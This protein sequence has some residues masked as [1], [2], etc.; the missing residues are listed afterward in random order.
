[1]LSLPIWNFVLPVYAYWHFDDFSWGQ[2][3]LVAGEKKDLGHGDKVGD[4]IEVNAV[5]LR[6]WEDWERSRLRRLKRER[7]RKLEFEKAFGTRNFHNQNT[8][9][10][11]TSTE[12]DSSRMDMSDTGSM[13]SSEDDRWGLQIGQYA[14]ESSS[15]LPPVGLYHIDETASDGD[16]VDHDR[17]EAMLDQGWDDDDS[18]VNLTP[19]GSTDGHPRYQY[20]GQGYP[21][22]AATPPPGSSGQY[23]QYSQP[24][25]K[26][27]QLTDANPSAGSTSSLTALTQDMN[28]NN[29]N[30]L[31]PV[32]PRRASPGRNAYDY[33]PSHVLDSPSK[34]SGYEQRPAQ[35]GKSQHVKRRSGG[36]S[37]SAAFDKQL[38]RPY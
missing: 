15:Y 31:S 22:N 38:P 32:S 34:A 9:S 36:G 10:T 21:G 25:V 12:G 33:P 6:R 7:K 26:M 11:Y 18:P 2:T 24:P 37:G 14:E 20:S 1:M 4:A 8:L 3:R 23:H 5:P 27:Y 29:G 16:T 28:D 30:P 13:F 19:S 35:S 17:L